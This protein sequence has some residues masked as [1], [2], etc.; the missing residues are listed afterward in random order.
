MIM[1]NMHLVTGY[2]G[3]AHVTAADQGT[4]HTAIFGNGEFVFDKGNKLSASAISSNTVRVLDGDIMMQGRYIRLNEDN[5][6]DLTIESGVQGVYRHDLI[7]VRYT[8]DDRTGVEEVNL[9]VIKGS[10]AA[11][12]PADP[13]YTAGDILE[14]HELLNEMPLYRVVLNGL[15]I[16]AVEKLFTVDETRD[17]T[18]TKEQITNFPASMPASDVYSWAKAKNK[19]TY[20]AS[21]VGAAPSSHGNHVP[22]VQTANNATFLRNDNTW[23]KVTPANIG[24][25]ESGHKHTKS[26]ITDFPSSMPA[27]DVYSWAKAATKPTYTASD[28]GAAA[29]SHKHDKSEITDFPVIPSGINEVG[30]QY[31][32]SNSKD[33]VSDV[34]TWAGITSSMSQRERSCIFANGYYVV[35]GMGGE[36]GYSKDGVTW[37]KI[38][39]FYSKTLTNIAYGK[40]KFIIVDE[41]SGLWMAEET[42]IS[43]TKIDVTFSAGI[44]SLT[45]ANNRFVLAGD[46]MCAFSEDGIKWTEVEAPNEHN[47]IAFGGGRYVAVG[48]GGAVSVSYDGVTWVDRRNPAVTGDLRGVVYAKGKYIIGGIDGLIMYTEDFVTWGIATSSSTVRYVRQITYAENKYYAACY[49][50]AGGG[51]IWISEDGITWTVQQ[52]MN[53]RLWCLSYND[54]QLIT[55]GD[56]GEVYVLDLGIEWQTK[57]PD[58][59]EGQYLW[60]RIVF[61]LSDGGTVVGDGVCIKAY[62]KTKTLIFTLEDGSTV[63][64]EVCIK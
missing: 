49:T 14:K 22:A 40:G 53:V 5:F 17:H 61:A 48:A 3:T 21:E 38:T 56:N 18:H 46:Y 26:E 27:S 39:P 44:G 52:Q 51:E 10:Y 57:Q 37:T 63:T 32:V 15:T 16:E 36:V 50:T 9:A 25:S 42:P 2:A 6:V 45:Y 60:E 47:Q 62:Q 1:A 23:Q 11:S 43:W 41:D 7:V 19:P 28:V 58:L 30:H 24:A 31:T 59:A 8:K 34:T 33:N 64:E 29:V 54:G 20:T 35:C 12:D 13:A 4:L 55:A